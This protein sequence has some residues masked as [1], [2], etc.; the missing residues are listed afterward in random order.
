[1]PEIDWKAARQCQDAL[2]QSGIDLPLLHD[3]GPAFHEPW[4]AQAFAMTLV[5]YERGLFSWE[6][7][8]RTLS[9][10][11]KAAQTHGDPDLGRTYYHHWLSALEKV[12]LDAK[13]FS[14]EQ[15][16]VRQAGWRHATARTPHG[17]PIELSATEK[18][19]PES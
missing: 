17:L 9:E 7:W 8:A 16:S 14:A 3:D 19:L 6:Q 15:L 4:Q 1:M 11:I 12:A 18:T 13:V 5:L 10:S 2:S